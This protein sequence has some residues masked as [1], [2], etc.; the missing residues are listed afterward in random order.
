L[1]LLEITPAPTEDEAA[2]IAAALTAFAAQA[3][4]RSTRARAHTNGRWRASRLESAP[5]QMT[6]M[7]AAR[8][9]ALDAG[10]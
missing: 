10:V 8:A 6:W 4:A 3:R 5:P 2:A 1:K 7:Q 9:E